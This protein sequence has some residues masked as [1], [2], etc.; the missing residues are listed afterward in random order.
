MEGEQVFRSKHTHTH[1]K[2]YYYIWTPWHTNTLVNI[3]KNVE[4]ATSYNSK[5]CWDYKEPKNVV[6]ALWKIL[7]YNHMYRRALLT[8]QNQV[9]MQSFWMQ[10][11]TLHI[12]ICEWYSINSAVFKNN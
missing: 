3:A 2:F 9:K 11:P 8:L 5:G 12:D 10:S 6:Q 4:Y 1:K 7:S